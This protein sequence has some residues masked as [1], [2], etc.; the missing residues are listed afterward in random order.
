MYYIFFI[1]SFTDEG[2]DWFY[3]V[4]IVNSAAIN[5]DKQVSL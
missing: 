4:A 3:N 2:L 1:H 5:M